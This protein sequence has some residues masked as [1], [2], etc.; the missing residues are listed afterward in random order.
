MIL[1]RLRRKTQ[2]WDAILKVGQ[3]WVTNTFPRTY[4]NSEPISLVLRSMI[5][6]Q[7]DAIFMVP[8]PFQ[9]LGGNSFVVF[10]TWLES[11]WTMSNTYSRHAFVLGLPT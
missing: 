1:S 6:P 4:L 11:S 3:S 5:L 10:A 9:K 7:K 2:W 8:R